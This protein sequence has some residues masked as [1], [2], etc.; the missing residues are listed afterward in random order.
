MAQASV[1]A[2]PLLSALVEAEYKASAQYVD[3]FT[4]IVT[5]SRATYDRCAELWASL[6]TALQT[7]P[8]GSLGGASQA[9]LT[10]TLQEL[11]SQSTGEGG[12]PGF[13]FAVEE[14][15]PAHAA[16]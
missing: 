4:S 7:S 13:P 10:R 1:A 15:L 5:T 8:E 12:E 11:R 6:N 9:S 3:A 14:L 16:G 2:L